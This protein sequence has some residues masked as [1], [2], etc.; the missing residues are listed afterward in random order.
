MAGRQPYKITKQDYGYAARYL[1]KA[2]ERGDI[3]KTEGYIAFKHARNADLLQKWCD[4]YLPSE[5]FG[6]MKSAIRASRKRSRDYRT[7]NRKV[8]IDLD[9]LAHVH[10]SSLADDLSMSLSDTVLHLENVYWMAKKAGVI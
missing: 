1:I 7:S 5:V 10:L 6:K 9:H 2:M 3:S 8:G 4:D